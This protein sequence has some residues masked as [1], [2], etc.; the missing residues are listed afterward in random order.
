MKKF[1]RSTIFAL[2]TV[3][4]LTASK[5]SEAVVGAIT[6]NPV[7]IGTGLALTA[8]GVGTFVAYDYYWLEDYVAVVG[9][10][11]TV[12]GLVLLDGEEGRQM[13]FSQLDS[14]TAGKLGITAS[15]LAS[16]NAEIDQANALVL[17]V[18]QDLAA[19]ENPTPVDA[20]ASWESLRDAVSHETFSAMQKISLQMVK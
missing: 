15:E 9:F 1:L 13:S 11:A 2:L 19:L 5:P 4:T 20:Q 17:Q 6:V 7:A 16:F 18:D 8:G 14:K 3:V 10:L 12:S